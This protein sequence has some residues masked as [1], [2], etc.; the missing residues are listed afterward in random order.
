MNSQEVLED[1]YNMYVEL[2][3]HQES[4][5]QAGGEHFHYKTY[6]PAHNMQVTLRENS[7]IITEG[8]TG[9]HTWQVCK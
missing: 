9:L 3:S 2:L 1:F 8:T 4:M 7:N 5:G 6:F